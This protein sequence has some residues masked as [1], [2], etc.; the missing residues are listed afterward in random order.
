MVSAPPSLPGTCSIR[1]SSIAKHLVWCTC[2][3]I[4]PTHVLPHETANLHVALYNWQSVSQSVCLSV[5]LG[6]EPYVWLM[7][8]LYVCRVWS[9][10]FYLSW[11]ALSDERTGC[12][13]VSCHCICAFFKQLQFTKYLS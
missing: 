9:L 11:G 12:L 6:V 1:N 4:L 2:S 10:L 7:T 13:V 8:T 3:S 5:C